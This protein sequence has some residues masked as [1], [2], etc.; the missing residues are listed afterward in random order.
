MPQSPRDARRIRRAARGQ[1]QGFVSAAWETMPVTITTGRPSVFSINDTRRTFRDGRHSSDS[2]KGSPYFPSLA[3][4]ERQ[5]QV[6]STSI[7]CFG[8]VFCHFYPGTP[9]LKTGF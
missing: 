3:V 9:H 8:F 6:D 5:L 7:G 2:G 4:P 1:G